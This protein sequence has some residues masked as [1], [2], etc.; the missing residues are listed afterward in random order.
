MWGVARGLESRGRRFSR[1]SK[2]PRLES[3]AEEVRRG[4]EEWRQKVGEWQVTGTL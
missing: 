4:S 2:G 1:R 3:V